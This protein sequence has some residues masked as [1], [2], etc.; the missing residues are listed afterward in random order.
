MLKELQVAQ[1]SEPFYSLFVYTLLP[2]AIDGIMNK[3]I[4]YFIHGA[5]ASN[6]VG[7]LLKFRECKREKK[8]AM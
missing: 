6:S 5:V 4:R 3:E 7:E 8:M 1:K 2:G